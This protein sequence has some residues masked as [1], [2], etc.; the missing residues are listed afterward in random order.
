M[1]TTKIEFKVD[2]DSL[3]PLLMLTVTIPADGR[4]HRAMDEGLSIEEAYG[5]VLDEALAQLKRDAI[6]KF[7]KENTYVQPAV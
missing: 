3:Q 5:R 4:Y 6:S 7:R 1:N 2:R